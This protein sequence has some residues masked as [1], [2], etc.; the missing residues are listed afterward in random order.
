[1][2]D[3]VIR[4]FL[5]IETPARAAAYND[6]ALAPRRKLPGFGHRVYRAAD[7]RASQLRVMAEKLGQASGDDKWFAIATAAEQRMHEAKGII[8]NV[9]YF[10]A[11]V[12]YHLG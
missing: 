9:D 1:A 11:P 12:L 5:E 4:M 3:E 8:A 10:A 2:S 7:P 6:E